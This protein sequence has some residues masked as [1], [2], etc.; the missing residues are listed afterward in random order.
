MVTKIKKYKNIFDFFCPERVIAK[1]PASTD[2]AKA[3]GSSRRL[4]W[5]IKSKGKLLQ[6]NFE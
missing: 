1:Y 6:I 5:S 2:V 3:I 4:L